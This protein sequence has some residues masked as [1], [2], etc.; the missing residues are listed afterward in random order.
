MSSRVEIEAFLR[1]AGYH[2][3][4]A[5][6]ENIFITDSEGRIVYFNPAAEET[7]KY[8]L[9]DLAGQN[10]NVF[11]REKELAA[12]TLEDIAARGRGRV[13]EAVIIDKQGGEHLLSIKKAPLKD[14]RGRLVGFMAVS[15][16]IT[17]ERLQEEELR[18][19]KEFNDAILNSTMDMI[20]VTDI[21]GMITYFN[22]AAERLIGYARHEV[23]GRNV[24]MFYQEKEQAHQSRAR[25]MAGEASVDY[26]AVVV[27]KQGN[28]HIFSIH[29]APLY[30]DDGNLIGFT[31]TSRD[32][33]GKRGRIEEIR[34]L[35]EFNEAILNSVHDLVVVTDTDGRITYY[36]PMAELTTGRSF[37]EVKGR[38]ISDFYKDPDFS[39]EKLAFIRATGEANSYQAVILTS[40]GAERVL[41]VN[42]APLHDAEGAL[43]GFAAVS[44]DV[45]RRRNA[46]ERVSELEGILAVGSRPQKESRLHNITAAEIIG[47]DYVFCQ[48]DAAA[49]EAA[50]VL[51]KHDLPAL[52]VV[53]P[54]GEILG[55][56]LLKDMEKKGILK[57]D[58][59]SS[60]AADLMI[61]TYD[62]IGP[63]TK[64]FDI[65]EV[66]YR[67]QTRLLLVA[68][69]RRLRGVLTE[70][71]IMRILVLNYS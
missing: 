37:E 14:S 67:R 57:G 23:L 58:G 38:R 43:I 64:F 40:D 13:Y 49:A 25:I 9:E 31:S 60:T 17:R 59:M 48:P 32:I 33:T 21:D 18:A 65:L 62:T 24:S 27:D 46:E 34:R 10:I 70:N 50:S 42:K 11:Y 8:R 47:P 7:T 22:P 29:K 66:M 5:A 54:E 39:D 71:D 61:T 28:E 55:L 15:R 2:I 16:D 45:T 12:N 51:L 63:S 20:T 19:L 36:N 3:L 1:Q 68:E 4:E 6:V 52:P 53:G 41:E 30:D 69:G 56:V 26:E 44:R 35:K